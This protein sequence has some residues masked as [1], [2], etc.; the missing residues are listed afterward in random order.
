MY[1]K[2]VCIITSFFFC[3]LSAF[4]TGAREPVFPEKNKEIIMLCPQSK[5]GG[6]DVIARKLA[7]EMNKISDVTVIVE[8]VSG[9]GS[10]DGTDKV[11]SLPA[12][13]YTVLVGGSHTISTTLQGLTAGDRELECIASLNEDPYILAVKSD[14]P[15]TSFVRFADSASA[16][17]GMIVIGNA[18]SGSASE[19]AGEGLNSAVNHVFSIIP[20]EGSSGLIESL[21]TGKCAAGIFS[22]SEILRFHE[23]LNPLVI[24]TNGH[25]TMKSL[26]GIPT[27]EE[28]GIHSSIPGFSYRCLMVKKGTDIGRKIRLSEI[29]EKAYYSE[30]FQEFQKSSGL[31]QVFSKLDKADAFYR[32]LSAEYAKLLKH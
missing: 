12:D 32:E 29:I 17:K 25:S 18:G 13:G 22:Q 15:Y 20:S 26:A 21:K 14:G 4:G 23:I 1:K 7:A 31:I 10:A 30:S 27:L 24:L 28:L 3:F 2:V 6:T 19:A 9:R 8:N 16:H 11:L 5:G